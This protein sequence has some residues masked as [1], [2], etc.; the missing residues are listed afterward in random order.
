MGSEFRAA[1][2]YARFTFPI[3]ISESAGTFGFLVSIVAPFKEPEARSK[4]CVSEYLC[5]CAPM[6]MLRHAAFP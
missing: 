1:V 5:R 6:E 2:I 3:I 4:L